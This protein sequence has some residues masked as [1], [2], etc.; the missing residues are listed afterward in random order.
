LDSYGEN[1]GS[2]WADSVNPLDNRHP[3]AGWNPDSEHSNRLTGFF[4]AWIYADP[5]YARMQAFL[6][7]ENAMEYP[8]IHEGINQDSYYPFGFKYTPAD[9]FP[10]FSRSSVLRFSNLLGAWASSSDK[11]VYSRAKCESR[12]RAMAVHIKREFA[13]TMPADDLTAARLGWHRF[14][15]RISFDATLGW[16][17]HFP[18]Y[19]QY[20]AEYLLMARSVGLSSVLLGEGSEAERAACKYLID[21]WTLHLSQ[22]EQWMVNC[23]WR[24]GSTGSGELLL[25]LRLPAQG[26]VANDVS[27]IPSNWNEI[28]T[29]AGANPRADGVWHVGTNDE[30]NNDANYMREMSLK[31][32]YIAAEYLRPKTDPFRSTHLTSLRARLLVIDSYVKS[33]TS[34]PRSRNAVAKFNTLLHAWPQQVPALD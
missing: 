18:I 12:L 24:V 14:A 1:D 20:V 29:F 27:T 2:Q 28:K 23:P 21:Q 9:E 6:L 8:T 25:P 22:I 5:L 17:M 11:A 33:K 34:D 26:A 16:C 15:T 31:I 13:D 7:T 30:R 3:T 19:T 10:G 4:A 32:A